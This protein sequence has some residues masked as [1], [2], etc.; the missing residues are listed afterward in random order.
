MAPSALCGGVGWGESDFA[1]SRKGLAHEQCSFDRFTH[2]LGQEG[3]CDSAWSDA[4]ERV[5][6]VCCLALAMGCASSS[7]K[8][9]DAA[10]GFDGVI[11]SKSEAAKSE[12][13]ARHKVEA[14]AKHK[15]DEVARQTVEDVAATRLQAIQRGRSSKQR[16]ELLKHACDHYCIDMQAKEFGTCICGWPKLAHTNDALSK[17]VAEPRSS[18]KVDAEELRQ[19]MTQKGYCA[20]ER[21]QINLQSASF[22]ECICGE[23]KANHSPA[24]LSAG[25]AAKAQVVDSEEVRA[26]MVSN[27]KVA[28]CRKY[29]VLMGDKVAFGT[30]VCGRPRGEHS[31]AALAAGVERRSRSQRLESHV[32]SGAVLA[33]SSAVLAKQ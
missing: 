10:S 16:V 31:E 21:Y 23:P 17:K 20:C 6:V 12:A 26:R 24:A 33:P 29:E 22:G 4:S 2:S 7:N 5:R 3:S 32:E 14:A 9:A 13:A 18:K 25:E 15:V 28:E 27:Q 19:R 30:C 8:K 11:L 1:K